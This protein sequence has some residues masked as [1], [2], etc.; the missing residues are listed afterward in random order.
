M[1][2]KS[3]Q[4]FGNAMGTFTQNEPLPDAELRQDA[5]TSPINLHAEC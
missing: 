2:R 1:V 5:K 4:T 3:L